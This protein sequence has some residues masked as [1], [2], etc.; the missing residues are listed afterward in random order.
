MYIDS[1]Y[2]ISVIC[3]PSLHHLSHSGLSTKRL[4]I[5]EPEAISG[6]PIVVRIPKFDD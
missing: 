3:H 2:V 6:L 4:N 1:M 5:G